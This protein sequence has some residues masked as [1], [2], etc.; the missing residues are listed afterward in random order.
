MKQERMAMKLDKPDKKD[1][2]YLPKKDKSIKIPKLYE[3]Q[4]YDNFEEA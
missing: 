4:F 3:F 1:K 2:E